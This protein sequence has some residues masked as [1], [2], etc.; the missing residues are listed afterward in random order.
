MIVAVTGLKRS[1]KNTTTDYLGKKYNFVEYAF[2]SPIKKLASICFNWDLD[3]MENNKEV[4]DSKWGVSP[5]EFLQW[6]GTEVMQYA[7][8]ERF[9]KFAEVIGRN[10]WVK[11]FE[12]TYNK[13][14]TINYCI[15]DF[16]FPHEADVLSKLN[17]IKIKIVN[18]RINNVD[19]HESESYIK[20]LNCHYIINNDKGFEE[21]YSQIDDIMLIELNR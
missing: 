9:P 12:D 14:S 1:G 4:I 7:M 18:P 5:R 16:R 17:A 21:L 8:C 3:Y 20:N 2:A 10:L 13:N 6:M 15:S 11:L 19:S